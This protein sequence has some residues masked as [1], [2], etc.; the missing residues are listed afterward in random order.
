VRPEPRDPS[1]APAFQEIRVKKFLDVLAMLALGTVVLKG[2]GAAPRDRA[3][4]GAVGRR[5][6]GSRE[7][8]GALLPT[9]APEADERLRQR[10][11]S[12]LGRVLVRPRAV[13]VEVHGG[14]VRLCGRVRSHEVDRVTSLVW[15]TPGV[16]GIEN[17][18]AVEP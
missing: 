18:L 8:R 9:V 17:R 13:E 11:R 12:G 15:S 14:E 10:L 6:A 4:R 3:R 5:A 16:E 2:L 1:E 7:L